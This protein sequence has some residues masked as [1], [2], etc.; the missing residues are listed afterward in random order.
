MIFLWFVFKCVY[1]CVLMS[2]HIKKVDPSDLCRRR[3][4]EVYSLTAI[5]WGADRQLCIPEGHGGEHLRKCK[6]MF[7]L[8]IGLFTGL[9]QPIRCQPGR[10]P[11]CCEEDASMGLHTNSQ[12]RLGTLEISLSA[13][14]LMLYVCGKRRVGYLQHTV[15]VRVCVRVCMHIAGGRLLLKKQTV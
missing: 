8:F 13:W 6:E 11:G 2:L 15:C 7:Q 12:Q 1:F 14:M 4:T 10:C 3:G 5:V 9:W